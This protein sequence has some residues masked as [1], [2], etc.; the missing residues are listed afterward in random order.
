LFHVD[1]RPSPSKATSDSLAGPWL[2]LAGADDTQAGLARNLRA[3]LEERGASVTTVSHRNGFTKHDDRNFSLDLFSSPEHLARLFK[4]AF[5]KA[6][7]KRIVH[8][9]ALDARGARDAGDASLDLAS[10]PRVTDATCASALHLLQAIAPMGWTDHP[11]LFFVT[12]NCQPASGSRDVRFPEQALLWGFAATAMHEMPELATTLL[13]LDADAT[14]DALG[15]EL[16]RADDENR[17]ALRGQER[18]VPRLLRHQR[19]KTRPGALR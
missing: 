3:W 7:P 19:P 5:R 14:A 12:K 6:P 15:R 11:R 18:L 13:D 10:L 8:L 2:L 9:L 1:W 17:I 4:D 16:A